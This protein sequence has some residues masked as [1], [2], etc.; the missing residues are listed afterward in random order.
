[1]PN[2]VTF[3]NANFRHVLQCQLP[4]RFV[5]PS[6]MLRVA[7]LLLVDLFERTHRLFPRNILQVKKTTNPHVLFIYFGMGH[8][9]DE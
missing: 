6:K 1:M 4:S 8:S 2:S 7:G 5:M 9:Q 3:C